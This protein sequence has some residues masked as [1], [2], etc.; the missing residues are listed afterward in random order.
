MTEKLPPM[1][2]RKLE[3]P[4]RFYLKH[5]TAIF[6]DLRRRRESKRMRVDR[7]WCFMDTWS[8]CDWFGNVVPEMFRYLANNAHGSPMDFDG[9]KEW[10]DWL[11]NVASMIEYALQED[12]DDNEYAEI[13]YDTTTRERMSEEAWQRMREMYFERAKEIRD[14][15]QATIECAFSEIGKHFYDLWD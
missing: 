5:P 6:R 11:K 8:W 4:W 12:D 1:S 13:F 9:A 14:K 7:G 3:M 2:V 10:K 15:K